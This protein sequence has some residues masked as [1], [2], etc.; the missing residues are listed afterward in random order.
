M[1]RLNNPKRVSQNSPKHINWFPY[2]AGYSSEFVHDVL[3][4]ISLQKDETI[5]DPWN[6]SGTT[7][8]TAYRLGA[9]VIGCDIN[10]VMVVA[11]KSALLEPGASPS[12]VPLSEEILHVTDKVEISKGEDPLLTWYTPSS[13]SGLRSIQVSI[14][15]TLVNSNSTPSLRPEDISNLST[16]ASFFIIA[17]MRTTRHFLTPFVGS[18]P[19][20]IRRPDSLAKRIR[21]SKDVIFTHFK[22]EVR[23]MVGILEAAS[24]NGLEESRQGLAPIISVE[25]ST[26]LPFESGSVKAVVSSP[27][28]LTRIDY[29]VA[30]KP[31]LAALGMSLSDNFDILRKSMI[32]TTTVRR[33]FLPRNALGNSCRSFLDAVEQHYTKG[34]RNY[35]HKLFVQYF[36]DMSYS[37]EEIARLLVRG[38][39]CVLVVQDSYYKEIHADLAQFITEM[40]QDYG[41]SLYDRHDFKWNRNMVRVNSR[42]RK[43][44]ASTDAVESALWFRKN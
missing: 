21:P 1:I 11:A 24:A 18:N 33:S 29:A 35:Y 7:T 40:A 42:A 41:L 37:I 5:L 9:K 26:L 6:G 28:Y 4:R 20:W 27:P 12:L 22:N 39:N 30:T 14:W 36:S 13:A 8:T 3:S 38:G 25:S 44:R 10:P 2:Y 23:R 17:L 15:R 31:E 19:T 43:Y 34:S 32:G 16:L